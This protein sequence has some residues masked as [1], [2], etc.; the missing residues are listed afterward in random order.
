MENIDNILDSV[1][2]PLTVSLFIDI[3][4]DIKMWLTDLFCIR[5]INGG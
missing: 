5:V 2:N 3:Y 4:I 1:D